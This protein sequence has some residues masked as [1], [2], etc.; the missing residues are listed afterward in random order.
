MKDHSLKDDLK[1]LELGKEYF[2][3]F[4][5]DTTDDEVK[6]ILGRLKQVVRKQRDSLV[7]KYE[8]Q[9]GGNDEKIREIHAAAERILNL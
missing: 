6:E 9:T 4:S 5:K 3:R 1:I 7:L 8:D 2:P